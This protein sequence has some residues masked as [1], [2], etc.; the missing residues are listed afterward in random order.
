MTGEHFTNSEISLPA[1]RRRRKPDWRSAW[2]APTPRELTAA[3]QRLEQRCPEGLPAEIEALLEN[4]EIAFVVAVMAPRWREAHRRLEQM[5]AALFR[6]VQGCLQA[7][8]RTPCF[9]TGSPS[10]N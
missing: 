1:R 4:R 2:P 6:A 3:L 7:R 10:R 8:R 9:V 5:D